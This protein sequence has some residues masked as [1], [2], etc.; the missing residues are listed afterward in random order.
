MT[1]SE[2]KVV[3]IHYK[4]ADATS[5]EVFDSSEDG[6]PMIY[7][8]GAQN[9]IPGLEQALEGKAAGDEFVVTVE[10][11]DAYGDYSE[12]RIQQVPIEAFEQMEKIEPGM[13]V[14]A[15]SDEGQITLMVTEVDETTVTVD[16][17]HPLAGKSLTFDVKVEAIRDASEEEIEHGH[18]HGAGGHHHD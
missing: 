10:S 18:V 5:A 3:S 13:V 8:H 4:V 16:A 7:L 15:Q 6:D 11:A 2:R 12:D 9:I 17:N 14:S 1:I